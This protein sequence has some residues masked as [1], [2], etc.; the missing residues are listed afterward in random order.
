MTKIKLPAQTG[1]RTERMEVKMSEA[2]K[3]NVI[4]MCGRCKDCKY[5][6]GKE[7]GGMRT[8]EHDNVY[9]GYHRKPEDVG[10]AGLIIEGD[11]GW[12]WYSGPEFG[13][14]NFDPVGT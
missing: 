11:E 1:K 2:N 4:V 5:W 12:G 6:V 8:C 3:G 10:P 7:W 9:V 13:C 14:V